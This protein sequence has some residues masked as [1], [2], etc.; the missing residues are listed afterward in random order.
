M[1]DGRAPDL[2]YCQKCNRKFKQE[3]SLRAHQSNCDRI[4]DERESAVPVGT[5]WLVV[6]V[7]V[8][9]AEPVTYHMLGPGLTVDDL[10]E[11][12]RYV[13]DKGWELQR[14]LRDEPWY[15]DRLVWAEGKLEKLILEGYDG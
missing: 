13:K 12:V 1:P 8:R 14:L 7:L 5:W 6:A 11:H 9:D 15:S 4:Y 3:R 2:L 10:C